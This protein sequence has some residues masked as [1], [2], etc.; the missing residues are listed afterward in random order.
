VATALV[1]E[2][3]RRYPVVAFH[4]PSMQLCVGLGHSGGGSNAEQGGAP[5]VHSKDPFSNAC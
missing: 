5:P 4:A 2:L 1:K 3:V